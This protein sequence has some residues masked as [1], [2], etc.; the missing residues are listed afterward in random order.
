MQVRRLNLD[1][2]FRLAH[3]LSQYVDV[4]A[5]N[6]QQDAVDFI[7]DIVQKI[8]PEEY[9]KC[10]SLLTNTDIDTIKKEFVEKGAS[11]DILTAFIEGMKL[12]QVVALLGFYKSLNL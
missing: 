11:L 6:P 2:A 10:V 7:G 8:T 12:N 3:I 4:D 1:D 5:L 9:L